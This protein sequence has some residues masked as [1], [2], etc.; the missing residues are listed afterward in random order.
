MK[1]RPAHPFILAI[2]L[3]LLVLI[4]AGCPAVATEVE[5][6]GLAATLL[7]P[8]DSKSRA[9]AVIIAGSG[10]TD[11]N[12]NSHLGLKTD[13]YKLLAEALLSRG[14]TTVRFDKRGIGGSVKSARPEP[15]VVIGHYVDDTVR[16]ARWLQARTRSKSI[17][18]I[19][20]S[21][22]GTLALLAARHVPTAGVVLL[23]APGRTLATI[24]REQYSRP[25]PL[26]NAAPEAMSIIA[27]LERG[28]SVAE[29]DPRLAAA[30][31][32][33]VQPYLRSLILLDPV[34]LARDLRA[35]LLIVGGGRDFQIGKSDF[36]ALSA[37]R[38]DA[39]AYWDPD[40][41]HTLK[42][43]RADPQ[44][45]QRAYT[46]PSQPLAPSLSDRVAEFILAPK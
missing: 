2:V 25:G 6:N 42:M 10:P 9:A 35:P 39:A 24:L 31:R 22:G 4:P 46:D 45:V 41:A 21:E 28:E 8:E 36:D 19:G 37:S 33:S 18:L 11:R 13:A 34:P 44:S 29:I 7:S 17:Y 23:A 30:F 20:H 43:S 38:S 15:E 32:P 26:R 40:M 1:R 5:I 12:G 14:I 16:I 3:W 27:A